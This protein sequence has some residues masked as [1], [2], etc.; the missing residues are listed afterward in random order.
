MKHLFKIQSDFLKFADDMSGEVHKEIESRL[1][2]SELPTECKDVKPAIIKQGI[3]REVRNDGNMISYARVRMMKDYDKEPQYSLGVK[4]FPLQQ[5]AETEISKTMFDSF[6]PDNLEKPQVKLRYALPNGWTVDVTNLESQIP[7]IY[8]EYEHDKNEKLKIPEHWIVKKVNKIA[9]LKNDIKKADGTISVFLGGS[10][11]D[12][13]WRE[14][15]KTEYGKRLVLLDPYDDN[16]D[17]KNIYDECL[18][19]LKA[20]YVVFYQ[21]GDLSKKEQQFLSAM[22]HGYKVFDDLTSLKEYLD[23]MAKLSDEYQELITL[24]QK[25]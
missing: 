12:N 14:K 10:T 15:I 21:G 3:L 17:Y 13:K 4:N 20:Y 1:Q 23:V 2:L 25:E 6:Y 9:S 18:G 8:A 22:N 16:W 11:K 7:E 5:E 19:M 24:T